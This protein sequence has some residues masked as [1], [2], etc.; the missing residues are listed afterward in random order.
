MPMRLPH[1]AKDQV[2]IPLGVRAGP[3]GNGLSKRSPVSPN[4]NPAKFS[5][6][7]VLN[8]SSYVELGLNWP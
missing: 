6:C 2:Q 3:G 7:L 8:Y 4:S 1:I 5:A